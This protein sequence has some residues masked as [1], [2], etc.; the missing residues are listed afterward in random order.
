MKFGGFTILAL[1]SWSTAFSGEFDCDRA[2]VYDACV[3]R[4]DWM[5]LEASVVQTECER[6]ADDETRWCESGRAQVTVRH[7]GCAFISY[8]FSTQGDVLKEGVSA[9]RCLPDAFPEDVSY[10]RVWA[11]TG[12]TFEQINSVLDAIRNR[13]VDQ[14]ILNGVDPDVYFEALS[15]RT[16]RSNTNFEFDGRNEQPSNQTLIYEI[17]P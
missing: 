10:I 14:I 2:V 8:A 11:D 17:N 7:D 6:Y 13:G 15:P 1:M 5:E 9:Q 16:P 3:A 4:L 12:A